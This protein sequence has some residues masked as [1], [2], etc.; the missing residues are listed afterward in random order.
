MTLWNKIVIGVK[1]LFSGF[2]AVTDY[3]L[4]LLNTFLCSEGVCDKIQTTLSYVKSVLGFLKKY[5]KYC[6]A[7]WAD[8]FIKL[9]S[10]IQKLVDILDDGKVTA[11]EASEAITSVQDAIAEWMK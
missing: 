4:Q 8:D 10:I 5:E 1:F 7:I 2:E 11:D 9:M 3:V 6:P